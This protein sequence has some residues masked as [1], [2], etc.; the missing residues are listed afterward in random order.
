MT[1][2]PQHPFKRLRPVIGSDLRILREQ[3]SQLTAVQ[4]KSQLFAFR[5]L[6]MCTPSG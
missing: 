1:Q 5:G 2:L 6:P 4:T 3:Q